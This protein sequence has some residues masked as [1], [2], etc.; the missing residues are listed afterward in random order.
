MECPCQSGRDF[1]ECCGPILAGHITAPTPEALMRSRFSA[2]A[3]GELDYLRTTMVPEHQEE[4]HP[5]DARRWNENTQWLELIVH[6][7]ATDGDTGTVRFTAIFRHKES[8][9]SLTERSR[10]V[11]RDG[12]W[13][14]LDGEYETETTRRETPKIG[15]N[16]PC[17]C[18]SGKKFKKCCGRQP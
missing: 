4:F 8:T 1:T 12:Q 7:T 2:F 18:G 16:D 14:Y 6:D 15:R 17:P 5:D 3:R 13:Y 9:Q 11:R 10:F